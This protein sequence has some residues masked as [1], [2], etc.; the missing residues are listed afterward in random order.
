MG[1]PSKHKIYSETYQEQAK[2]YKKHLD[3]LGLKS[4]TTQAR[5][6]YLKEFFSWLENHKIFEIQQITP[7]AIANYNNYLKEK[8]SQKTKQKLKQKSIYDNMRNLQQYFGYLLEIE[9]IKSNPASHLKFTAVS[10]NVE[11]F[12]FSQDQIQELYKV[13]NL[14]E[15]TILNMGYG[16]GLR[17]Q[18]ISDLNQEDIRLTENIII[19][20]K[21]KNNK[22]RLVP[23]TD[24]IREELEKFIFST[25]E[26]QKELF[27]NNKGQRMQEWGFNARL[28]LLILKTAF[29]QKLTTKEL[30]K[31]GIHSLRHSIAT[32]LL[33][34]G[35][36][37]EQVQKFL[38]HSHIESTEIYTHITNEQ[39]KDLMI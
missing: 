13:A 20:Q 25:K 26:K 12:I 2:N 38:G 15:K 10:E 21:G 33:E 1:A 6:L 32:H 34:N 11:R 28:K 17:V 39:L 31:I 35:M 19:V 24:K 3:I 23:I 4:E 9:T 18:E 27:K 14:Q 37:L 16:C 30:N 5:Y 8:I 36:K 22:R 29:G 7:K